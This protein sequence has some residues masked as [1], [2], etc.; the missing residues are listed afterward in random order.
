MLDYETQLE[1]KKRVV[2]QSV[3]EFL[4]LFS[5]RKLLSPANGWI[6]LPADRIPPISSTR[7][8][9]LQY[10]YRT[11]ITPHFHIPFSRRKNKERPPLTKLDI[12]FNKQGCQVVLD[13]E[14][15]SLLLPLS[16]L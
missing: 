2:R 8:S 11:K 16:T 3:S 14:V 12:G 5:P 7:G 6:D 1:F 13:I 4:Q 9:P 15:G 10:N